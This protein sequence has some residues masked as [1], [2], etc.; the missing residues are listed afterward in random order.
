MKVKSEKTK[1]IVW[2]VIALFVGVIIGLLITNVTS[3]KAIK[4]VKNDKVT[5]VLLNDDPNLVITNVSLYNHAKINNIPITVD[6]CDVETKALV[7]VPVTC[8]CSSTQLNYT[9]TCDCQHNCTVS[10]NGTNIGYIQC[11]YEDGV[12]IGLPEIK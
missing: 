10:V 4:V 7:I 5:G 6:P 3:G 8:H 2:T 11:K 12:P 9:G 1:L